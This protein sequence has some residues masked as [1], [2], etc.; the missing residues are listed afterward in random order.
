VEIRR[1]REP[2]VGRPR[3]DN[4]RTRRALPYVVGAGVGEVTGAVAFALGARHGIAVTAVLGSELRRLLPSQP[5]SS[6][7]NT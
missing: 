3:T 4:E 1:D 5:S 6:S 7:T 2:D